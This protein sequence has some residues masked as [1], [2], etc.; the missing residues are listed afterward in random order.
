LVGSTLDSHPYFTRSK[1]KL[2]MAN[3]KI[4]NLLVDPD[5]DPIEEVQNAMMRYQAWASGMPPSPF[6]ED[7]GNISNCP[8]LSQV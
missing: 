1:T 2:A 3:R 8:P 5:Q 4:K 7:L 6:P